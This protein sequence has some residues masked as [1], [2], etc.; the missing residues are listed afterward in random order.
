[1]LTEVYNMIRTE[2][3]QLKG[4]ATISSAKNTIQ[5]NC[6]V[7]ILSNF[8]VNTAKVATKFTTLCLK[9]TTLMLHTVTSRHIYQFW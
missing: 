3:L 8:H 2:G 9:K 4:S 1:M 6:T 7:N 5:S